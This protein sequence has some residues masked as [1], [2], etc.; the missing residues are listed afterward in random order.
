MATT[1]NDG[2]EKNPVATTSNDGGEKNPVSPGGE[3]K[4]DVPSLMAAGSVPLMLYLRV[5]LC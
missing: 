2:G 5:V 4:V 1:S 3:Q